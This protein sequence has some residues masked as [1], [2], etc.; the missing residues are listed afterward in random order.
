MRPYG[1]LADAVVALH[2]AF[3]LFVVG[4]GL[5]LRRWRRVAWVHL[6]AVVWAA[7]VEC[8]G[9]V[10]PLTP[11][12]SWLRMRGGEVGYDGQFV[13]RYVLP[14]LY[15]AAL[16]RELQIGLGI[17]VLAVNGLVYWVLIRRR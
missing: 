8:Q 5:L 4:G 7:L 1:L 17:L 13:E 9:W 16:T 6:P 15:P 3:I 14:V 11:L 10:C 2:L 12:E